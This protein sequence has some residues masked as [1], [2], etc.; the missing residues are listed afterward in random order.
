MSPSCC[1][2]LIADDH[3]VIRQ[4]VCAV[5]KIREGWQIAGEAANGV[6]ALRLAHETRPDIAILDYSLPQMDGLALTRAIKRELPGIEI[7]IYT[8][9]DRESIL[10]EVL[11]A[12]ALGYV[13]KSDATADLIAAVEA[14]AKHKR[15]LSATIAERLE[16]YFFERG[17]DIGITPVLTPREREVVQLIADGNI[18]K[19]I[20]HR[21]NIS[22]KTVETHRASLM[23]KL[24]MRT[25]ADVVRYAIRNSMVCP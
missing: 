18:N 22:V 6:D 12:G 23:H 3:E 25:T 24:K 20:A 16:N 15:Y 1:R 7:L 21:L 19:Q 2:I 4:G 11:E 10:I 17:R 14:M 5:L 8:M 13:L 9:H